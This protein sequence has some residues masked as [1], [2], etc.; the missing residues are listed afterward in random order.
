MTPWRICRDRKPSIP[1]GLPR[2]EPRLK[3]MIAKEHMNIGV[4]SLPIGERQK[5]SVKD[6]A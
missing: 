2:I 4:V 6:E 3:V 1:A 5:G